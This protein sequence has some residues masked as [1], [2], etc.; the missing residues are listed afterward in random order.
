MMPYPMN[1]NI[2]RFCL[3]ILLSICLFGCTP[4]VD[5]PQEPVKK[6]PVNPPLTTYLALGDSY[7]I[8]ESVEENQRWP[9][10]LVA[11][12]NED[13]TLNIQDPKIIARTG[14]T[15]DELATAIEQENPPE[16]YGMVS[17]LIG[18]NNQYRG[19]PFSQYEKEFVE[20]L[21][22]AIQ[23]AQGRVD[24][25]FVVSIPDYGATPFGQTRDTVKITQELRNY[26]SF[27]Q[28]ECVE[29]G[30]PFFD[31]T[32]SSR[33]ARNDPDL[34]AKD[35]LHP[36]GKMYQEWVDLM[37]GGVKDLVKKQ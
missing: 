13:T 36:S 2:L 37:K 16:T 7:T 3:P 15:T 8:G 4:E 1:L 30:I 31:I 18:V 33:D 23:K 12:L 11:A 6:D 29:R 26:N 32:P 34:V 9:L 24:K 21:N 10:Q 27:A 19:Y 25:V 17:L 20:L 35:G 14:W 28:R 5:N 22:T